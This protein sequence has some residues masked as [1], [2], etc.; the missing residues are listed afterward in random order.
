[1]SQETAKLKLCDISR[2]CDEN[3]CSSC[4]VTKLF[5]QVMLQHSKKRLTWKRNVP[6][7]ENKQTCEQYKTFLGVFTLTHF[8]S[9]VSVWISVCKG[10][11]LW[12]KDYVCFGWKTW[13]YWVKEG[14]KL[15]NGVLDCV[16]ICS[17]SW[18]P[19]VEQDSNLLSAGSCS[20]AA[21]SVNSHQWNQPNMTS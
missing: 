19:G 21:D 17:S 16:A 6:F 11:K 20:G 7:L 8:G 3:Q 5:D 10:W 18:I 12:N 15:I 14:E 9:K 2:K 4:C 13:P 1:M